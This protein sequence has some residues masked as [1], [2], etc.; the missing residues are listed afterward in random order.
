ME[1]YAW[2]DKLPVQSQKLIRQNVQNW[3]VSA[4]R[5]LTKVSHDLVKELVRSGKKTA[6]QVKEEGERGRQG[7]GGKL[8]NTPPIP[9]SSQFPN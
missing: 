6:T 8:D 7:E 4:L 1:I 2:F 9:H 3:S 5:Q